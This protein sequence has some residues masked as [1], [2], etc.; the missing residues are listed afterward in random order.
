[1]SIQ[2][3]FFCVVVL[4]LTGTLLLARSQVVSLSR[5]SKNARHALLGSLRDSDGLLS[6]LLL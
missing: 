2:L 1:M 6:G 4:L 3:T 5:F